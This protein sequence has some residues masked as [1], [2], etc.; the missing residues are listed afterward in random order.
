M[1]A[2]L[3]SRTCPPTGRYIVVTL[4]RA[5]YSLET[6]EQTTKENAVAWVAERYP[7]WAAFV[8]AALRRH[9][10]DTSEEHRATVEFVDWAA[11]T[12]GARRRLHGA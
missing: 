1:R 12:G 10:A 6:G 4:C 7:R 11:A 8:D 5:L 9:R 2:R 3:G